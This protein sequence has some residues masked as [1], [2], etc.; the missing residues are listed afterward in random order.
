MTAKVDMDAEGIGTMLL[1]DSQEIFDRTEA[2]PIPAAD[3][4]AALVEMEDRPWSEL[5]HG[6]PIT[7]VRL[8]RMLKRFQIV[9]AW[10]QNHG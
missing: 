3:L 1:T 4:V 2:H 5:N 7:K 9:D 10:T 6:K 8:S